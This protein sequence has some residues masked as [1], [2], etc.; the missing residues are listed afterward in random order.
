MC[1]LPCNATRITTFCLLVYLLVSCKKPAEVVTGTPRDTLQLKYDT[2][3]SLAAD[4]PAGDYIF[5]TISGGHVLM[6]V[7]NEEDTVPLL[8]NSQPEAMAAAVDNQ[9][10]NTDVFEGSQ[11]ATVKTTKSRAALESNL[12]AATLFKALAKTEKT[13]CANRN[14]FKDT[15]RKAVEER[16]V[17]LNTVYLYTFKRQADEDYHLIVGSTNNIATAYFFNVEISGEPPAGA[18]GRAEI[19]QARSDFERYFDIEDACARSYYK[20]DFRRDPIPIR[21]TGSLFFD[22]HHCTSFRASG[23][24]KWT[25]IELQ[26]A[27]EIHPITDIEFL[28]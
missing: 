7:S 23:P 8:K 17:K 12:D 9:P 1:V 13:D 11:R 4:L 5:K 14:T 22:A 19:V 2:I 20:Q 24:Q 27:W 25:D 18:Y 10:C 3:T 28:K 16:N 26:T 6:R 15:K 21:I